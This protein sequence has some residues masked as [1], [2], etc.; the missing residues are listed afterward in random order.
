MISTCSGPL[1]SRQG[2]LT[3]SVFRRREGMPKSGTRQS[4]AAQLKQAIDKAYRLAAPCRTVPRLRP[5]MPNI[6]LLDAFPSAPQPLSS[7]G[8][9]RRVAADRTR[10]SV[11]SPGSPRGRTGSSPSRDASALRCRPARSWSRSSVVSAGSC[12][13]A[14]TLDPQHE[15]P[16]GICATKPDAQTTGRHDQSPPSMPAFSCNNWSNEKRLPTPLPSAGLGIRGA[17]NGRSV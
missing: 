16:Y 15:A 8:L 9:D 14:A 17:Q 13:P 10:P 7:V 11:R 12:R 4:K 3:A 6:R 1:E 5:F 2:M